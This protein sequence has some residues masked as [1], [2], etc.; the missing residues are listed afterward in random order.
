MTALSPEQAAAVQRRDGRLLLA[1]GAG[2]GK[3]TVMVERFAATVLEDE[4]PVE[5]ILAITFTEKA[6][7]ELKQRVRARLAA[8]GRPDLVRAAES[9]SVS[10][11][12]GFC[13]RLLRA[14]ALDAGL[15]P[16][17]AVLDEREAGRLRAAAFDAALHD[18]LGPD[19]PA[20]AL[21]VVAAY[22]PGRVRGMAL[23]AHAQLRSAGRTDPR[24]PAPPPVDVAGA[25]AAARAAAQAAAAELTGPA[26]CKSVD[27][28]R[29]ALAQVA[30]LEPSAPSDLDAVR[31]PRNGAAAVASAACDR[32][33]DALA[34]WR[35][36]LVDERAA[37]AL[38][39]VGAILAA[40]AERYAAFKR[41]D[42]GLDF[43]DL[44]LGV[45]DLLV[46]RPD[47]RERWAGRFDAVM[48]DEFQ[49]VNPLQAE[50]LGLIGPDRVFAV[51][52]R[53]QSIYGF[54]HA[55]VGIFD[56]T[57]AELAAEGRR[58]TLQRNHRSR[59][60]LLDA[61]DLAFADA[62][63][64][65]AFLPLE[66]GRPDAA[67]PAAEPPVEL[68]V[69]DREGWDHLDAAGAPAWRH[70]EARALAARIRAE[71][72][73]GRPPGDVVVLLRATGDMALYERA[74]A[75]RDVPTYL[76][77]GRGFWSAREVQDL[78]AWLALVAN[79][80]DEPRLWE[81]LASPMVGLTSDG[82]VLVKAAARA[83]ERD[84]WT[85]LPAALA[86]WRG[87]EEDRRRLAA[88]AE[89]LP[90]ERAAAP[91][92]SLEELLDRAVARTGYDLALLRTPG[93]RRRMA[94]VRKLLRLARAHEA[95]EGPDL[96]GFL[97]RVAQLARGEAAGDREGEAPVEGDTVHAVR[98]M[99]VH[100]AKGLEFEVVCVA[101]L[102]R[103]RP[104]GRGPLRV[105]RDRRV[106]LRLAT[107]GGGDS[108]PAF[109]WAELADE[110]ARAEAEEERRLFYVAATRARERLV[111]S[112][113][114]DLENWPDPVK[115]PPVSWLAPAFAG[116]LEPLRDEGLVIREREGRPVRVRVT[117]VTPADEG[118]K[119]FFAT[120]EPSAARKD[121]TPPMELAPLAPVPAG[122]ANA[123]AATRLSYSALEDYARC[124][125]RYHLQRVLGLPDEPPPPGVPAAPGLAG[126]VRGTIVHTL[127]E[128]VAFADPQ[129]PS[130]ADVA[131]LGAAAGERV[132]A[133]E[134][135][136]LAAL[137]GGL[138]GSAIAARLAAAIDVRRE[139][140]FAFLVQHG[141]AAG[142]L[143]TGALDVLATEADGAAL[144][145]DW[146]SDR[147][148]GEDLAAVVQ[149]SYATQRAVYALA[150]LRA[151]WPRVEVV[152]CFLER[153]GD[154]VAAR[155]AQ[156]DAARLEGEVAGLAAPLLE[157]DF[158]PTP[159]PHRDLCA[160]C[161]GRPALCSYDET[162]T[163]RAPPDPRSTEVRVSRA[164]VQER[165][166]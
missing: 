164:P 133:G 138:R 27:G 129:A 96:R 166:F 156:A 137:V 29:A 151:G 21:D 53:L 15:D 148:G 13:A 136:A 52:D 32:Y 83:A 152:H 20:G 31:L 74:L 19:G 88:F 61:I 82:L 33:R 11:I 8:A 28:A 124:G 2:T 59:R 157:G 72:D 37:T 135:T 42:A 161:P 146:K 126:T 64:P 51:G 66:A 17:A 49:D 160:T 54:R 117:R 127:L 18:A 86:D 36:A 5:R 111:L 7:E 101:D 103:S 58:A 94:N 134:A 56:R 93:G 102:G 153:P 121:L 1:A 45:R 77:G 57:A 165:L 132:P 120:P 69:C 123:A 119:S 67:E 63:G 44:E 105:G 158:A 48:V 84:P 89:R 50:I 154:T 65:G 6:A 108:E 128:R 25:A 139:E 104:N 115:G 155:F 110:E 90:A 109:A 125:Y 16:Y 91:R 163:L 24:L 140:G 162:M 97:D 38:R 43:D 71:L 14:H 143:L 81:V 92:C 26:S 76:V 30:L 41:A 23:S 130:P 99:T 70:A 12:H 141:P 122:P 106:G 68:I 78:V 75:D 118:V 34:A 113:A 62:F 98:L 131:A 150:A 39:V 95:A 80:Y 4:V 60:E 46:G 10:T 55:D 159:T 142:L 3:T 22:G 144:V 114:A 35:Q 73:A 116:G 147:V 87:G 100:R 149:R 107:L 79:P 9:A 40:F 85:A 112:G 47:L 145:V